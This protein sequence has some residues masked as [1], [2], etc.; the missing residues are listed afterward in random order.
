M[1]TI[2]KNIGLIAGIALGASTRLSITLALLLSFFPAEASLK[3]EVYPEWQW[4]IRPEWETILYRGWVLAA[5]V[6]ASGFVLGFRKE[7]NDSKATAILWPWFLAEALMLVLAFACG[8][9][10]WASPFNNALARQALIIVLGLSWGV[11]LAWVAGGL[12]PLSIMALLQDWMEA[13][14][15]KKLVLPA[16]V[17]M[18][19]VFLFIP[20][21]DAVAARCWI[22]EQNHHNDSFIMAPA[23]ALEL[24]AQLNMD[25]ISQY[26][27]GFV[28]V[29][30]SLMKALGG[31]TYSNL[32]SVMML[33]TMIYYIGWLLLLRAVFGCVALAGLAVV[34]AIKWQVFH[35]GAYPIVYTYGSMTVLRYAF[36]LVVF[37]AMWRHLTQGKVMWLGIAAAAAGFGVF[38][39]TSEGVYVFASYLAYLG[40]LFCSQ[41]FQQDLPI[42]SKGRLM[43]FGVLP[44]AVWL[45]LLTLLV[46]Q[47][48]LELEFWKNGTEFINYFLSGFGVEPIF[49]NLQLREFWRF[50]SGLLVPCVYLVSL[51]IH[52]GFMFKGRLTPKIILIMVLC[53]YGLGN[54]HYYIVRSAMTNYAAVSLGMAVV[55]AYWAGALLNHY[56][57]RMPKLQA[58]AWRWGIFLVALAMLVS[59][60][61][62]LSYPNI[63]NT[64]RHPM[65]DS[66]VAWPLPEG[67]P[68]FNHLFNEYP[69][70]WKLAAN[71]LQSTR[72][73]LPIERNFISDEAL[74]GY[75]KQRTGF[76]SDAAM[77]SA[78]VPPGE[79]AALISSFET[80][81]LQQARRKPFF[82]YFPLV[83]SRPMSMRSW[84]AVSIYTKTQ[85]AKTVKKIRQERPRY[86]FMENVLL[87]QQVP[88]AY[89][90][91]YPA[92]MALIQVIRQD[93]QVFKQGEYLTALQLRT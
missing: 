54:Y 43:V 22:G 69:S 8:F 49:K 65:V 32:I 4:I 82:Y 23:V 12:K 70:A 61:L 88:A 55:T 78:L 67:K 89:L 66:K 63:I 39:M 47:S 64:S 44:L 36:D 11:S 93:Y 62:F 80:L 10:Y 30:K 83:I 77:I 85:L 79:P 1:T 51:L 72:E 2:D 35:A 25:V 41:R 34:L 21:P 20:R 53:I 60:R 71:N 52:L 38:Y 48:V 75:W 5:I 81:I 15:L 3:G 45:F 87:I 68:Y 59:N 14:W 7:L 56:A 40:L 17:A 24:G 16:M 92:L 42:I 6:I 91:Q 26:G 86:I 73:E 29:V 33:A 37:Y 57:G 90:E 74:V 28:V 58:F 84:P 46:G 13:S 50:F 19:V 31:I 18:I 27:L 76:K 9:Q